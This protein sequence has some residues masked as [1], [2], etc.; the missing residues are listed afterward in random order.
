MKDIFGNSQP[1]QIEHNEWWFNGRII[2]KQD[3]YRL[4]PWISFRDNNN[5]GIVSTH[6]TKAEATRFAIENPCFEPQNFPEN[7]IGIKKQ[8]S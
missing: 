3:D 1:I 5:S 4:P 7:Y 2:I 6:L 8:K